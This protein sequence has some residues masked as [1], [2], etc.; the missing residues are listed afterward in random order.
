MGIMGKKGLAPTH[1]LTPH[2]ST[3]A[4]QI[5]HSRE[6]WADGPRRRPPDGEVRGGAEVFDFEG[7]R[8]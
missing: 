3:S 5:P 1:P 7:C 6:F 2:L 8:A 4:H